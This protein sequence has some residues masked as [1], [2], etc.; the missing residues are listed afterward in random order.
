MITVSNEESAVLLR[1]LRDHGASV[2]DLQ[3]SRGNM[4][5]LLPEFKM[6]GYNYR[7]TDIQAALGVTQMKRAKSILKRRSEIAM[8][9]TKR[10]GNIEWL[11]LPSNGSEYKHGYQSFVCLFNPEKI[12]EKNIEKIKEYRNKFMKYLMDNG[13]STR[14][15]THAVHMLDYYSGKY[16]IKKT[17]YMNSYIADSC[18]VSLPVYP[19]LDGEQTDYIADR[20]ISYKFTN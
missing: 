13:I 2:S 20:I 16:G 6:L 12:N 18:S 14:P 15:G 7:M 5:Y 11:T 17:D 19:G 10:F 3:R 8:Q 1:S 9:Y 4:P